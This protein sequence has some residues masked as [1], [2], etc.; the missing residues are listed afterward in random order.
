[1]EEHGYDVT[2][3]TDTVIYLADDVSHIA[4]ATFKSSIKQESVQTVAALKK[5]GIKT[6]M[7]TGD[8]EDSRNCQFR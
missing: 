5:A 2:S 7:L 4:T 6:V 8:N 3:S 1:M